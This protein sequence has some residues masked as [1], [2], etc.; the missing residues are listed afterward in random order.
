LYV[1]V[2]S[3]YVLHAPPIS[4]HL[5][6]TLIVFGEEKWWSS[7]L[8]YFLQPTVTSWK[9][10]SQNFV[11]RRL[12]SAF[13][14]DVRDQVSHPY[15]NGQLNRRLKSWMGF[16]PRSTWLKCRALYTEQLNSWACK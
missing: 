9:N 15:R 14:L 3:P 12:Q 10:P 11:L 8:C 5:I 2:I 16:A 4:S 7:S 1:F 6:I 13:S